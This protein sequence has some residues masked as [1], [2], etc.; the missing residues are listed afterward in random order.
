GKVNRLADS[1]RNKVLLSLV[2]QPERD[3]LSQITSNRA[4]AVGGQHAEPLATTIG[5]AIEALHAHER[6]LDLSSEMKSQTLDQID[7]PKIQA[8]AAPTRAVN[9][10]DIE[11][12]ALEA[13]GTRVARTRAWANVHPGHPC[14]YA[15]GVI[16]LVVIPDTPVSKPVPSQG[17]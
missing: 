14:L 2:P 8:L 10:L 7:R 5:R 15:P 1:P 13:P 11:R 9:L 12:L 6:L 4:P 16:T 3:Q 17:L